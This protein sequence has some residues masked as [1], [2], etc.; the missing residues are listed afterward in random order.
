VLTVTDA[1]HYTT[2]YA[3][4]ALDRVTKI[5]DPLNNAAT[6]ALCP[7]R[8]VGSVLRRNQFRNSAPLES[9]S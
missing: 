8:N 3:Y 5:T 2:T 4:D 7:A 1:D 6:Y 9:R